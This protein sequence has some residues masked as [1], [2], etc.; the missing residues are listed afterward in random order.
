MRLATERIEQILG[1]VMVKRNHL[2]EPRSI[3]EKG[4]EHLHPLNP[5]TEAKVASIQRTLR[6]G[7]K[8]IEESFSE[9]LSEDAMGGVEMSMHA[10][11][12]PQFCCMG[13]GKTE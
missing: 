3:T 4:T 6:A 2:K 12:E 10:P 7:K 9:R 1:V 5:P 8:I 13:I 11:L